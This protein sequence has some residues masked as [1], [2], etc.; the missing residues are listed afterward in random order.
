M[1]L[2]ERDLLIQKIQSTKSLRNTTIFL[3]KLSITKCLEMEDEIGGLYFLGI[4][5]LKLE[6]HQKKKEC[7]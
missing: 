1:K 2:R 5:D 6:D 3:D 7:R 4:V